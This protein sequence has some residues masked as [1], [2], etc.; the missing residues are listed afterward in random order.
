ME[1]LPWCCGSQEEGTSAGG[2]ALHFGQGHHQIPPVQDVPSEPQA[3]GLGNSS[4]EAL[5]VANPIWHFVLL[6]GY[7]NG[8]DG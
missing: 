4:T 1:L 7:R 5:L 2:A 6:K 3:C 8:G